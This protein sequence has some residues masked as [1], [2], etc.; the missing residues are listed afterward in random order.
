MIGIRKEFIMSLSLQRAITCLQEDPNWKK[1]IGIGGGIF[2]LFLVIEIILTVIALIMT[3]GD[4]EAV[5]N[6]AVLN[7][8]VNIMWIVSTVYLTGYVAQTLN[9]YAHNDKYKMASFGDKNLMLLGLK[10]IFAFIG[11]TICLG[12]IFGLISVPFFFG[13]GVF[14]GL[15]NGHTG[16]Q[17]LG[18]LI[19]IL[20]FGIM[21]IAILQFV[22]V[23]SA[24]YIQRLKVGDMFAFKKHFNILVKN[25]GAVWSLVGKT[26]LYGLLFTAIALAC[27]V[28]LVG[29]FLLPFVYF[30]AYFVQYNLCVQFAKEIDI[31]KYLA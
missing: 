10:T 11:Y 17:I 8:V 9:N 16:L 29:I 1:N 30:Y 25:Q 12:V 5:E 2:F 24:C 22:Y 3:G 31:E 4:L 6:N 20:L 21:F 26:I 7:L 18:I 13:A 27:L 14:M 23:A 28:T 15:F 19:A